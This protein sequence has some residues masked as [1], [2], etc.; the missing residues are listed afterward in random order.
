MVTH[1]KR[2]GVVWTAHL[3]MRAQHA[4]FLCVALMRT[5]D[6]LIN[7]VWCLA[8]TK[9]SLS[10]V[11]AMSLFRMS[12]LRSVELS[13]WT[14]STDCLVQIEREW[15]RLVRMSLSWAFV[16]SRQC[17]FSEFAL[18]DMRGTSALRPMCHHHHSWSVSSP[19]PMISA[20]APLAGKVGW[21]ANTTPR[22]DPTHST[23][24]ACSIPEKSKCRRAVHDPRV[25]S[26]NRSIWIGTRIFRLVHFTSPEWWCPRFRWA[27]GS[28]IA[29]NDWNTYGYGLGRIIQD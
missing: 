18:S 6:G 13:G 25:L 5:P 28:G 8:R 23:Q 19:N 20:A 7:A 21:L 27:M 10:I 9:Q 29:F 17:M 4:H 15:V 24:L 11:V 3:I 1:L 26:C 12:S 16:K 14:Y 2:D 22:T